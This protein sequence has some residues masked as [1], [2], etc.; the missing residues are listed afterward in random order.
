MKKTKKNTGSKLVIKGF[1]PT[2]LIDWD[3]KIVSTIYIPYCNF[4][5]PFCHNP[6]LVLNPQD[7]ETIPFK[8]IENYLK[9]N[10]GWIDGVCI[11]IYPNSYVK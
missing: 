9:R 3:G 1:I 8:V 4:R 11:K 7:I 10:E 2:S 5:C 6:E